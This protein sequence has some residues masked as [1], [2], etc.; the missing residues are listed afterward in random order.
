MVEAEVDVI[1]LPSTQ[2]EFG[3]MEAV[4]FKSRN[5]GDGRRVCV[6]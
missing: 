3:Y 4:G 1:I 6:D 2:V 5:K